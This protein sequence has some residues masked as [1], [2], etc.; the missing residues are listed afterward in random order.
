[1]PFGGHPDSRRKPQNMANFCHSPSSYRGDR[2]IQWF[3]R[4]LGPK[5]HANRTERCAVSARKGCGLQSEGAALP[6]SR[7]SAN[8]VDNLTDS[9]F[10]V[11]RNLGLGKLALTSFSDDREPVPRRTPARP[12]RPHHPAGRTFLSPSP[13]HAVPSETEVPGG[14]VFR[15]GSPARPRKP[16]PLSREPG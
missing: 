4:G 9:H 5:P 7:V 8:P 15:P 6:L 16:A 13:A 1:M 3:D 2:N 10:C 12:S 11:A 14:S